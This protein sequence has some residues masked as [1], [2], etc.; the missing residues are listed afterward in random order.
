MS[1]YK[2]TVQF[3]PETPAGSLLADLSRRTEES[4]WRAL[5]QETKHIYG[6]DREALKARGY[7]VCKWEEKR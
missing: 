2:S 5:E 6:R 3:I 1:R 4:A 7:K